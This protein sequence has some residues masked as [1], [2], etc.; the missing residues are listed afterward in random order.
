MSLS[1]EQDI[2][3]WISLS[4]IS[5]TMISF[6]S[7]T[8]S[9]LSNALEVAFYPFSGT[10]HLATSM[11]A[12]TLGKKWTGSLTSLWWPTKMIL[13]SLITATK[14]SMPLP[15]RNGFRAQGE[16]SSL[17]VSRLVLVWRH[18]LYYL[19]KPEWVSSVVDEGKAFISFRKNRLPREKKPMQGGAVFELE[20]SCVFL[21][22]ILGPW[23]Y[24]KHPMI[25]AAPTNPRMSCGPMIK[26]ICCARVRATLAPVTPPL[27]QFYHASK[28]QG[29]AVAWRAD[30]SKGATSSPEKESSREDQGN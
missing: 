2:L 19:L 11:P 1:L 15:T 10:R 25:V 23:Q 12:Q 28:G 18:T 14:W 13:Q 29:D 16:Q 4:W 17:E 30:S 6:S 20:K 22:L 5:F 7:V 24:F 21:W 27:C 8:T 9:K 3:S 26:Q